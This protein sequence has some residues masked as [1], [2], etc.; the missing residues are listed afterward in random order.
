MFAKSHGIAAGRPYFQVLAGRLGLGAVR[1]EPA[2]VAAAEP[3]VVPEAGFGGF[4]TFGRC[5]LDLGGLHRDQQ[6]VGAWG[7]RC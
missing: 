5:G 3:E 1:P 2:P 4:E 7:G 6:W